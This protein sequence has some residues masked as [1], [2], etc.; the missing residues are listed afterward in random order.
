MDNY[1]FLIFKGYDKVNKIFS[2]PLCLD[3]KHVKLRGNLIYTRLWTIFEIL[4][5]FTNQNLLIADNHNMME[6]I[7]NWK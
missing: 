2:L 7:F 3:V 5:Q 4:K 1:F 6:I